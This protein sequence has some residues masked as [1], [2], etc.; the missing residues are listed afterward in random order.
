MK[1][2]LYQKVLN[3]E[4]NTVEEMYMSLHPLLE[5]STLDLLNLKYVT[6]EV[7]VRR[8]FRTV[9]S[10]RKSQVS[11]HS[12]LVGENFIGFG[13]GNAEV[14]ADAK[15]IAVTNAKLNVVPIRLNHHINANT[16]YKAV[17][18]KC[19]STIVKLEPVIRGS[20]LVCD[21]FLQELMSNI[22]NFEVRV[23]KKGSS[24]PINLYSA[25]YKAF[26]ELWRIH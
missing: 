25:L 15:K 17:S 6:Y 9:D 20:G 16:I 18:A 26:K 5:A 2:T 24:N 19:G 1:S 8:V 21:P 7:S 10:G 12:I 23:L 3:K 11:V 22:T 13:S 14:F 4:I